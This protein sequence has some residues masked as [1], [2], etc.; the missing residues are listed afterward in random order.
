LQCETALHEV[1]PHPQ[2]DAA[3][4]FPK[5]VRA[6]Y[7]TASPTII[8]TIRFCIFFSSF[9]RL[10]LF[11]Y[12][13]PRGLSDFCPHQYPRNDPVWYTATAREKARTVLNTMEKA[14]H[15]HPPASLEMQTTVTKQG[16]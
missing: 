3:F 9:V 15:F 10:T 13:L 8:T 2:D 4:F 1:Q 11:F 7:Q 6:T 12:G 5:K 14:P 16:A